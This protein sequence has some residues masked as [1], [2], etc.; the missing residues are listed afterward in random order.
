[1]S[2]K[3]VGAEEIKAIDK[4]ATNGHL[5]EDVARLGYLRKEWRTLDCTYGYGTFWKIWQPDELVASDGAVD[6]SPIGYA[7]DFTDLPWGTREFYV[8][9]FDPPYKLN[10][11]PDTE[12]VDERFGVHKVT[13]WQDRIDLMRRGL[14]ECARVADHHLLVKCQDQVC[15]GKVRWQTTEMIRTAEKCGFGLVD[16]FDFLGGR[17]QDPERGQVHARHNS[18]Q[19]LVFRRGWWT[20][21]TPNPWKGD[22]G[23]DDRPEK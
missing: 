5:I 16:R 23:A 19:L 1:M 9:V 3:Q 14:V 7:V 10:G 8:V 13:R 17:P 6:R 20:S 15:S 2:E 12:G 22:R 21:D 18:S 4:W 11:T